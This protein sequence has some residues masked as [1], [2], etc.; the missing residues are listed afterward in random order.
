MR[1]FGV[2]D[3]HC[4]ET[5]L[6]RYL[7]I[8]QQEGVTGSVRACRAYTS[9][10]VDTSSCDVPQ[11]T[12]MRKRFSLVSD[13]QVWRE[14]ERRLNVGENVLRCFGSCARYTFAV[15]STVHAPLH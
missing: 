5:N 3:A 9:V 13:V 8:M 4:I 12:S 15:S 1:K 6:Y 10:C 2:K 7:I 14:G 11:T